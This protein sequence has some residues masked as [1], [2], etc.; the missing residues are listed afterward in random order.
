M[1]FG[2]KASHVAPLMTMF[3]L[4]NP[5]RRFTNA[6]FDPVRNS[7]PVFEVRQGFKIV[8][9]GTPVNVADGFALTFSIVTSPL[10]I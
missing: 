2:P 8:L 7:I 5:R 10:N 6:H 9:D 1:F 4:V 3:D